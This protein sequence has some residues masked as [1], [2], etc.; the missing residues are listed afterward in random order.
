MDQWR[1]HHCAQHEHAHQADHAGADPQEDRGVT[2]HAPGR[3][4]QACYARQHQE[5]AQDDSGPR[6]RVLGG[7][8]HGLQRRDRAHLGGFPGRPIGAGHRRQGARH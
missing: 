5:A 6:H 7:G 4:Y 3:Q 1:Q 8:L 2:T